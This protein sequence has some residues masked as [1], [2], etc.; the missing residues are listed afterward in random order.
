[1]CTLNIKKLALQIEKYVIKIYLKKKTF[2]FIYYYLTDCICFL[3]IK[4]M[5]SDNFFFI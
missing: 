2:N 5:F 3:F 4:K 1:M